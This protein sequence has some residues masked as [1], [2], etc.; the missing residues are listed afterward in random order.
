MNELL[1]RLNNPLPEHI[2]IS[3]Y[4]PCT[5]IAL[6]PLWPL[7]FHKFTLHSLVKMLLLIHDSFLQNLLHWLMQ[8]IPSC[9]FTA[10]ILLLLSSSKNLRKVPSVKL[11]GYGHRCFS[12]VAPSLWNSLPNNIRESGSLSDFKTCIKT[13]LFNKFYRLLVRRL[14]SYLDS[15]ASQL[16][17]Y[18]VN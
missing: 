4:K 13:Y 17:S 8:A 3:C 14:I 15:L 16:V 9:T 1:T 18:L 12:F 10:L 2:C 6:I 11:V 5:D 7:H